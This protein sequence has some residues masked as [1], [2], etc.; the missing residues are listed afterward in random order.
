[1]PN[2]HNANPSARYKLTERTC[3]TCGKP[4]MGYGTKVYCSP[5]CQ[6]SYGKHQR[7]DAHLSTSSIGALNELVAAADLFRKGYE[8]FRSLSPSCSADM[9]IYRDGKS[10]RIEVRT[11]Y[12]HNSGKII[13]NRVHRADI[14]A[15]VLTDRVIYEPEL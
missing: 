3:K 9:V 14:L 4:F 11:G 15:I 10:R 2:R 13:A 8:V 5:E 1:M 12:V 7:F 6:K